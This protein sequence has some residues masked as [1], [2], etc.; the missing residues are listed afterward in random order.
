MQGDFEFTDALLSAKAK[1]TDKKRKKRRRILFWSVIG[2]LIVISAVSGF[3]LWKFSPKPAISSSIQKEAG[4]PLYYPNP[5]PNNYT[6]DK[7]SI[8]YSNGIVSYTLSNGGKKITILEQ[9]APQQQL[10]L[11]NMAGFYSLPSKN[12]QTVSGIVAGKPVVIVN[13]S[14]TLV[15]ITAD[16]KSQVKTINNLA[17]SLSQL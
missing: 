10:D 12:G 9:T 15:N 8:K 7:S 5:L 2:V 1:E 16:D 6:L 11:Q 13:T 14:T 17:T 3:L 4:Y